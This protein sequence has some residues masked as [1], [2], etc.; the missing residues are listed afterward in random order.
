MLC[1]A[2]LPA[3]ARP[4]SHLESVESDDRRPAAARQRAFLRAAWIA[5]GLAYAAAGTLNHH[6]PK[7]LRESGIES[8]RFGTFLGLVFLT[9]TL[10][11]FVI[12]P[13]RWWHYRVWPLVLIQCALAVA[14]LV[15]VRVPGFGT[16]LALAPVFGMALGFLYQSSLYYSLHASEGRGAQAGI[17]EAT[18]GT[19]GAMIPLLG[20]LAVG[21]GGLTAPF[22]VAAT[23]VI[24]GMLLGS[25][26]LARS[27]N[28][29]G[30]ASDSDPS[31]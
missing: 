26:W 25:S 6:L 11:F 20:G 13:R 9:Q 30:N 24:A 10:M 17:H 8:A 31:Q 3:M 14:A 29:S 7:L 28:Q 21:R 16:L 12:G 2:A 27:R 4:G 22:V 18:L 15:V 23:A 1:F 19:F 5:N